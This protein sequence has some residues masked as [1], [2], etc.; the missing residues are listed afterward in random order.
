MA[1]IITISNRK[2]GVAKTTTAVTLAHGLAIKGKRVLLVDIDPQGHVAPVLGLDEEPGMFDLLMEKRDLAG[3]VRKARD[4]LWIVPSNQRTAT[5]ENALVYENRKLDALAK[6]LS[7]GLT[8]NLDYLIFDT[9]PG[10]VG[11]L[12]QF[13]LFLSD[14][15]LVP[16]IVDHLSGL[17]V[18]DIFKEMVTAREI[19]GW[20]GSV[21]GILPTFHDD[22]TR[23]SK[24]QLTHL[25]AEFTDL[26]LPPIHRATILRECSTQG[27]TVFEVDPGSRAAA[28]YAALVWRV[29]DA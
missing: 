25:R 21:L 27:R 17:G 15:V 10:R 18:E 14:L 2:G 24:A 20:K 9:P 19:H 11:A 28:E 12:Q 22:R 16:S 13:A 1:T 26:V 3:V 5:A 8:G 23:E 4:N 7:N 6:P 29:L